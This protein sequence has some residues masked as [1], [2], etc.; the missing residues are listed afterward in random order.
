MSIFNKLVSLFE[1]TEEKQRTE[2]EEKLIEQRKIFDA[3]QEELRV[4]L[5]KNLKTQQEK[6]LNEFENRK[7]SNNDKK[8]KKKSKPIPTYETIATEF[9]YNKNDQLKNIFSSWFHE[10]DNSLVLH[11]NYESI[12]KNQSSSSSSS[13]NK[14]K[15]S[16]T[17]SSK[18]RKRSNSDPNIIFEEESDTA[19][20]IMLCKLDLIK[21]MKDR[22][23]VIYGDM[24]TQ[25]TFFMSS[26]MIQYYM[27]GITCILITQN[28]NTE[29]AGTCLKLKSLVGNINKEL[30]KHSIPSRDINIID[31]NYQN[32]D[33]ECFELTTNSPLII[34][35]INHATSLGIISSLSSKG[36]HFVLFID[37]ADRVDSRSI[38]SELIRE[39]KDNA[40][41]SYSVSATPMDLVV[42]N[43][44]EYSDY[45][46]LNN[47]EY[48]RGIEQYQHTEIDADAK[49]T[50]KIDDNI[51]IND[52]T[53]VDYIDELSSATPI[54]VPIYKKFM[55][56]IHI[57]A[58]SIVNKPQ[59]KLVKY[60][61]DM[62]KTKFTVILAV[63]SRIV[64]YIK[65]KLFSK[66][67]CVSEALSYL[68]SEGVEKHP[69]IIIVAG[70]G[71]VVGRSNSFTSGDCAGEKM[72]WHCSGFRLLVADNT[73]QPELQQ[74]AG[75]LCVRAKDGVPLMM[76][77]T[78]KI[79]NDIVKAY[80]SKNEMLKRSYEFARDDGISMSDALNEKVKMRRE[81]LC[82]SNRSFTKDKSFKILSKVKVRGDDDGWDMGNYDKMLEKDEVEDNEERKES[83]VD[84]K[85]NMFL[86]HEQSNPGFKKRYD[87]IVEYLEEYSG[88]WMSR[89]SLWFKLGLD[90][91]ER[92]NYDGVIHLP[93]I[94]SK[95]KSVIDDE[96]IGGLL[97][98]WD[99][100]EYIIRYN[101]E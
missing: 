38:T 58:V 88:V 24:Q 36:K 11:I 72:G 96:T 26:I 21:R 70:V 14:I 3:Q 35:A 97:M 1:T 39:L 79:W 45:V 5:E 25:K 37:E 90:S 99:G 51:I 75:R 17:K 53:I 47:P 101:V 6:I 28:S 29:K 82:K 13:S 71:K 40:I 33:P 50:T 95:N 64:L 76:Y 91:K 10:F 62:Y 84:Y 98:K 63:E 54:Y 94:S 60:I 80:W 61:N 66:Y 19:N 9:L 42:K 74:I 41:C 7:N 48:Y 43:N 89:S 56:V 59:Q 57:I 16:N 32:I 93:R 2:L 4:E 73:D 69:R 100:G 55:P 22:L 18:R 23:F 87:V 86:L 49:I 20:L 81:K 52:P 34:V 78:D 68:H 46:H 12:S 65:G 15:S 30:E 8:S 31:K 92:S 67:E 77:T 44:C 27:R 83:D 85:N